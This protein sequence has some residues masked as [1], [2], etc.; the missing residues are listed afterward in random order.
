MW[1]V[2]VVCCC[3]YFQLGRQTTI[4]LKLLNQSATDR[5]VRV[6]LCVDACQLFTS[7][8]YGVCQDPVSGVVFGVVDE[9]IFNESQIN[10]CK[11][12]G[13]KS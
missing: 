6:Y 2:F 1:H 10:A 13:N 3:A 7:S 5:S 4:S 12:K 9:T 8:L 11:K